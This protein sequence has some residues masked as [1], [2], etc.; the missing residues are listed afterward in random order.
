MA[1]GGCGDTHKSPAE[2]RHVGVYPGGREGRLPMPKGWGE[3]S[4]CCLCIC[5]EQQFGVCSLLGGSARG[6]N[7]GLR[8]LTGVFNMYLG[9]DGETWRGVI[10]KNGLSNLNRSGVQ[11]LDFCA[12]HG[13]SIMNT[14]FEHK[15]AHKCRWYKNT[16]GQRSMIDFVIVSSDL[17]P[18]VLDTQVKRAVN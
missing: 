16:L 5:P 9:N 15:D 12:S 13:L 11:L 6:P 4:D 10:G 17:R 14:M 3:N 1:P 8:G 18:C 2:R 7:G